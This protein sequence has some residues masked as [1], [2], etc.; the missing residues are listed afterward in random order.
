M[1]KNY[2]SR[3]RRIED[4]LIPKRQTVII[5]DYLT[6]EPNSWIEIGGKKIIIPPG[7]DAEEFIKEKTKQIKGISVCAVYLAKDIAKESSQ[8]LSGLATKKDDVVIA[9]KGYD[10]KSID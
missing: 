10:G 3:L 4:F 1:L 6:D 7:I 5:L 8:D 9:I 2:E